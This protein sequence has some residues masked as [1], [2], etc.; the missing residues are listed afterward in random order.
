LEGELEMKSVKLC[1]SM[2]FAAMLLGLMS[3]PAGAVSTNNR[4]DGSEITKRGQ[5]PKTFDGG[6]VVSCPPGAITE[7]ELCGEDKNGGCNM[8]VPAFEPITIGKTICGTA[9]STIELRDTDWYQVTITTPT[10]LIFTVRAEFPVLMGFIDNHGIA[11]CG[12][13]YNFS[14]YANAEACTDVNVSQDCP[15]GTYWLF[16]A[17]STWYDNPCG[18]GHNNYV[19]TLKTPYCDANSKFCDEYISNVQIG[20]I[21]NS[22]G[23]SGG[24]ADYNNLSTEMTLGVAYPI[25]VNNGRPYTG[26]QCGIWV[27]WNGDGDF[28]DPGE[29]ITV[30][31]T[32]GLGPYTAEIT[33]PLDAKLGY[34]RMRIRIAY[35]GEVSPCGQA[36]YGEVEDYTILVKPYCNASGGC[37]EYISNVQVGDI[38]NSSGCDSYADYTALST[39]MVIDNAYSITVTNGNPVYS[40]DQC[41]IWVDWNHN[42]NFDDP[43]EAITVSGTPG[44]GPYTAVIT[45]PINAKL[46]DTRMRV[47][48]TYSGEVSPCGDTMYGEVE[49]YTITV[50]P[51]AD[52]NRDGIVD[53]KD[54]AILADQ[55]LRTKQ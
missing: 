37:D 2:A 34:T 52:L 8:T 5:L 41:G 43:C 55:W 53:F 49:D 47:R 16:V 18:S 40:P 19:A 22:S 50:E 44:V 1:I 12:S 36:A 33:P 32:P 26:D 15:P 14:V 7:Q 24:Y 11:D 39:K 35:T 48:I 46:G 4:P 21:N 28:D 9:W 25:T 27:D 20:D 31:G 3:L 6:C 30:S 45:P 38:N 10:T 42:N 13:A 54:F 29:A 51:D 17:S 23:C